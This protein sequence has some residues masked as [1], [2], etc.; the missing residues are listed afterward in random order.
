MLAKIGIIT[1]YVIVT[2]VALL[3]FYVIRSYHKNKPLGMQSILTQVT[4]LSTTVFGFAIMWTS[5]SYILIQ[6]FGTFSKPIA[7]VLTLAD[8]FNS[9]MGFVLIFFIVATKYAIVYH[10]I[11]IESISDEK[12][13]KVL[14]LCLILLPAFFTCIELLK[15]GLS[16]NSGFQWRFYGQPEPDS[17]VSGSF[18]FSGTIVISMIVLLQLRIEYDALTMSDNLL[19][20]GF[21]V[22]TLRRLKIKAIIKNQNAEQNE[23]QKNVT[24][25]SLTTFRILVALVAIMACLVVYQQT[26]GAKNTKYVSLAYI[27]LFFNAFPLIL[28]LKHERMRLFVA[29]R[30]K[31]ILNFKSA[32]SK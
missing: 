15:D 28:I 19:E 24:E 31:M 11:A 20:V 27:S 18:V 26:G 2:I 30:T 22:K 10:G 17:K 25:Y 32:D 9:Q 14:K 7:I 6:I 13:I 1:G 4:I 21:I 23:G 3:C 8:I 5:L 29:S 16:K 12:V